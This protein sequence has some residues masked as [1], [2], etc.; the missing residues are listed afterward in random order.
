MHDA[1]RSNKDAIMTTTVYTIGHSNRTIEEFLDLLLMNGV[2][3][4]VDIRTI[5]KSRH[6]PQFWHDVLERSLV[7]AGIAYHLLPGLG[8]RR[9]TRPDSINTAWR[10]ASFRGYADHMQTPEFSDAIEDLVSIARSQPA[11]I[12]CAEA[13]PWRCHRSLVGD[14]LLVRGMEVMDIISATSVRPHAL[15]PWARVEGTTITYPDT[16]AAEHGANR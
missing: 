10:N 6:N 13:V 14:A 1:V 3:T 7:D 9:R 12:M 5:P 15:T 2:R 4:L 16:D 8:G 11:A